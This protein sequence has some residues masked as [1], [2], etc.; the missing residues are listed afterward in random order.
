M[1]SACLFDAPGCDSYA[2]VPLT[3]HEVTMLVR[4][5][6]EQLGC[7][8]SS[9]AI[10]TLPL[11]DLGRPRHFSSHQSLSSLHHHP[12]ADLPP[13]QPTSPVH[14]S[15]VPDPNCA[16]EPSPRFLSAPA[17]AVT[18]SHE[19]FRMSSMSISVDVGVVEKG[20]KGCTGRVI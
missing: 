19:H 17:E 14:S 18:A 15:T 3:Y 16:T 11:T 6:P 12:P 13:F 7:L 4:R 20:G 1:Q 2:V 9:S 8:S 10:S 5:L